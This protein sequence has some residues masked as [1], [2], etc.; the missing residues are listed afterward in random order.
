MRQ[1]IKE[2]DGSFLGNIKL[3]GTVLIVLK[4]TRKRIN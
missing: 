4:K 2:M 3:G 1:E